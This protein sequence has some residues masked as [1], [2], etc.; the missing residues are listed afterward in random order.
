[1]PDFMKTRR[2][3][4][5]VLAFAMTA[6]AATEA[7]SAALYGF[8]PGDAAAQRALEAK[9]DASLSAADQREWMKHI[10]ARLKALKDPK[11]LYVGKKIRIPVIK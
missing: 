3:A 5:P 1:M 2:L 4:V 11:K 10:E 7:P 8:A 9:F 6:A